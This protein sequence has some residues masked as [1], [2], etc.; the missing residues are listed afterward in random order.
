MLRTLHKIA[1]Y[2]IVALGCAHL[3]FTFHNY[4]SFDMDAVWFFGAGMAI[5]F[6]G[7]LNIVVLRADVGDRLALLLC[8][9]ADLF[10]LVGFA[11]ALTVMR[12]PQ[13]L[14][15]ALLSAVATVG[16]LRL[17]FRRA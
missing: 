17:L 16:V 7:F 5:V 10:L 3:L 14:T 2:L 9:L 1:S 15:G 13:V 6:A 8:L 12:Q 11:G 4:D